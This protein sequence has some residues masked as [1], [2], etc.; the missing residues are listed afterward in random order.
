MSKSIPT[1]RPEYQIPIIEETAR[2]DKRTEVTGRVRI[3]KTVETLPFR[4]EVDLTHEA[5]T[6]ERIPVNRE[7]SA[8]P[9]VR[10]EGDVTIVS[11]VREV[12]VVVKKLMVVEELHIRRKTVTETESV[13]GSVRVEEVSVERTPP[14]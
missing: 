4:E 11:V 10:Q 5:V 7:V 9:G 2:I 8:A 3:E 14:K 12:P 1:S 13:V 6:V